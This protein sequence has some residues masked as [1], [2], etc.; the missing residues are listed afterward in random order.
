MTT[1]FISYSHKDNRWLSRLL[2]HLQPLE[3]TG[4]IDLWAD[5]R[6]KAGED[7]IKQIDPALAKARVAVLLVSADFLASDF[8]VSKELPT[9]LQKAK[10]RECSVFCR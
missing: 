4:L 9:L 7:W 1:A 5:T 2:V 3:R 6:I 8:I 10:R